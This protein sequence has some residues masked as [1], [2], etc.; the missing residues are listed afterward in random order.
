MSYMC[1]CVCVCVCVWGGGGY[2]WAHLLLV[3]RSRHV[4]HPR[5][6]HHLRHGV[7]SVLRVGEVDQSDARLAHQIHQ[8]C[9]RGNLLL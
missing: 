1:A 2:A 9:S 8:L 5:L 4:H 3:G 7:S 6:A